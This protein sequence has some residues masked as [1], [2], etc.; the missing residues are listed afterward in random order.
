MGRL[1]QTETIKRD[2]YMYSMCIH[3][4]T[5]RRKYWVG[6]GYQLD[7]NRERSGPVICVVKRQT[8]LLDVEGREGGRERAGWGKGDALF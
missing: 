7:G 2:K 3:A 1:S 6:W 5:T 8:W 4:D